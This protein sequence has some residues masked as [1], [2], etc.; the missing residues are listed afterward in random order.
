[1]KNEQIQGFANVKDAVLSATE[2]LMKENTTSKAN[3]EA[4]VN[5]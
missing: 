5:N 1:M 4:I 3:D 2:D